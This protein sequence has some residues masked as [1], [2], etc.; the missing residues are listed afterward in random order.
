MLL[1]ARAL[2]LTTLQIFP[3]ARR[4]LSA[5]R[6]TQNSRCDIAKRPRHVLVSHDY[7][8]F[9]ASRRRKYPLHSN[10]LQEREEVCIVVARGMRNEKTE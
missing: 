6:D 2:N 3:S 9:S 8:E 10:L 4:N 5:L 1:R 7:A